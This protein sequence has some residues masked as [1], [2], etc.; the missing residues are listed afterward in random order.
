MFPKILM[1]FSLGLVLLNLQSCQH[2]NT[3][4]AQADKKPLNPWPRHQWSGQ[5]WAGSVTASQAPT[6]KLESNFLS[7][8]ARTWNKDVLR[9]K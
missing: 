1:I 7:K 2:P 8:P 5:N 6:I 9:G 4:D 3:K